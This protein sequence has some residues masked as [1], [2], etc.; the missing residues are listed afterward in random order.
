MVENNRR[1]F[2]YSKYIIMLLYAVHLAP[3]LLIF[4]SILNYAPLVIFFFFKLVKVY[5]FSTQERL[6]T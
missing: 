3:T 4:V 1:L 2:V 5:R 6:I